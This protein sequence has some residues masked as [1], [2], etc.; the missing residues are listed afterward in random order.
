MALR[1]HRHGRPARLRRHHPAPPHRAHCHRAVRWHRRAARPR[2]APHG[3][4]RR[5]DPRGMGG[6]V[7]RHRPPVRR[8]R[9]SR[10]RRPT[11]PAA[12]GRC[13]APPHPDPRPH[14]R[15]CRLPPPPRRCDQDH[16]TDYRH[17][18]LTTAADLG[19]LCR[20]DHSLKH[21]AGWTL[22]QPTTGRFVWTSPLGGRYEV[23]PEPVLPPAPERCPGPD[24]RRHDQPAPPGPD[25]LTVWRPDPPPPAEPEPVD[26][27]EPPPF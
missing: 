6:L 9:S 20:H 10:P 4:R 22:E 1:D 12:P 19:P 5:A 21:G 15:R 26:L 25:R 17:G 24:D 3:P 13:A 27:D 14:L 16:T 18:G 11:R 7:G 8:A 23:R 2:H